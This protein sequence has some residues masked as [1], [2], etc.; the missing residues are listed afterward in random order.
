MKNDSEIFD[1]HALGAAMVENEIKSLE[2]E[3]AHSGKRND[4]ASKKKKKSFAMCNIL[5]AQLRHTHTHVF[6]IKLF[7]SFS[8]WNEFE[9]KYKSK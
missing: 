2:V 7:F 6:A 4:M 3:V 5:R 9:Q 1:V 8:T